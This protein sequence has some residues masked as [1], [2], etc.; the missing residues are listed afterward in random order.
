MRCATRKHSWNEFFRRNSM[1]YKAYQKCVASGCRTQTSC[2]EFQ[3]RRESN[4]KKPRFFAIRAENAFH[5]SFVKVVA[6]F[7]I[8]LAGFQA[9]AASFFTRCRWSKRIP[10]A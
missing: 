8:C 2:N 6:T 9:A 7:R 4:C 3:G 10:A 1:T 5:V